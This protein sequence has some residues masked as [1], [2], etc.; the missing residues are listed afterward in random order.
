MPT[1]SP[2]LGKEKL[3]KPPAA[4]ALDLAAERGVR[5]A[6]A[7][8]L[9]V[10][11]EVALSIVVAV[12]LDRRDGE[13]ARLLLRERARL[14]RG[15]DSVERGD[16]ALGL[17]ADLAVELVV[18]ELAVGGDVRL[19][20]RDE[21]IDEVARDEHGDDGAQCDE[22]DGEPGTDGMHGRSLPW[23]VRSVIKN[24]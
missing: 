19:V 2:G 23:R 5:D 24:R 6:D 11:E 9:V 1:L 14:L 7:G 3:E 21:G 18:Q 8:L 12:A 13:R 22:Q 15:V 17:L 10:G 4:L 16:E 20:F